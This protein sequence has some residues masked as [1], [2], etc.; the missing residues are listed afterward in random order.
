MDSDV[1]F[2][3]M[4]VGDFIWAETFFNRTTRIGI[5]SDFGVNIELL[6]PCN[7][8][9]PLKFVCRIFL[10]EITQRSPNPNPQESDDRRP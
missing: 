1:F 8:F 3:G 5:F 6:T 10:S 2:E 4:G 9:I 7:I